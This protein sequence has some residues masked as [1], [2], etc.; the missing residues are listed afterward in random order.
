MDLASHLNQ[1]DRESAAR[2]L[3]G[4][5]ASRAWVAE[6][7]ARRPFAS[8]EDVFLA[9]ADVWAALGRYDFLEA[10]AGHPKIGEDLTALRERFAKT[11]GW[12][13]EEQAGVTGASDAV[14]EELRGS[15]ISYHE[16]FGYIFIVCATGKGAEEI[17]ELLKAR[18]LHDPDHELAVAAAEQAK[19]TRLRL[20]KL[21]NPSK[22]QA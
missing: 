9:A 22:E 1:L 18:L 3:A 11:A 15:N 14:L 7:L 17:L 6:M 2:T 5:C 13:S 16:R 20:E 4:C 21:V 8:T 12:S 10:F 19:I